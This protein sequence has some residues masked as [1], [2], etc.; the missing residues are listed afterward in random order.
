[1]TVAAPTAGVY[2]EVTLSR[3]A[4]VR[5]YIGL[6]ANLGDA[7]A[8]LTLAVRALAA[9]PGGASAGR[10]AAVR[11][12]PRSGS[13]TSLTSTTRSWPSRC[14][15]ARRRRQ[16]R[17]RSWSRSRVSSGRWAGFPACAGGLASLT[18]TSWC[19][20]ATAVPRRA[21]GG[22]P[23]C[24]PGPH[25]R[26]VAGRAPRLGP[27]ARSSCWHRS[28]TLPHGSSRPAGPRPWPT[29]SPSGPRS[30]VA[31]AARA[32]ASWDPAA[33]EWVAEA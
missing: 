28:P 14:R 24:R 9:L 30:R 16:G 27:G 32:V 3:S 13:P 11:D 22:R 15:A 10:V 21:R 25:R 23:Q 31:E 33:R 4:A 20:A 6:G 12:E 5:A 7:T 18:W 1:M 2:E 26:P 8:T 29:P 19:S 17:W